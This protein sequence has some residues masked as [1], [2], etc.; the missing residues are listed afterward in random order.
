MHMERRREGDE[1]VCSACTLRWG[2]DEE[3]PTCKVVPEG[4]TEQQRIDR[5]LLDTS[6]HRDVHGRKK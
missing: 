4:T 5:M 6:R 2:V 1:Y 3:E